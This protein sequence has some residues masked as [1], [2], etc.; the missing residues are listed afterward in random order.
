MILGYKCIIVLCQLNGTFAFT[1][2]KMKYN[3]KQ[4]VGLYT[5]AEASRG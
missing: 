5:R 4:Y 1:E 2:F 3:N